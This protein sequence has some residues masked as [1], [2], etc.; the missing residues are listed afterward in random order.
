MGNVHRES[1][2]PLDISLLL[3]T[4]YISSSKSSSSGMRVTKKDVLLLK[5]K[6]SKSTLP[7]CGKREEKAMKLL[8]FSLTESKSL[9]PRGTHLHQMLCKTKAAINII[10]VQTYIVGSSYHNLYAKNNQRKK[11]W[12]VDEKDSFTKRSKEYLKL[13]VSGI[14]EPNI[15]ARRGCCAW[16]MPAHYMSFPLV[17]L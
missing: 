16:D 5:M 1:E 8:L 12:A 4:I 9:Q 11:K 2:L 7:V 13:P 6:F 10:I 17:G 15:T 3:I 14:Q